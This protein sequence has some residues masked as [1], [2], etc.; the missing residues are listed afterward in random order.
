MRIA[1]IAPVPELRRSRLDC[2][3][4]IDRAQTMANLTAIAF[5]LATAVAAIW[6]FAT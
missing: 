1:P 6:F 4:S 3:M 2:V 5:G